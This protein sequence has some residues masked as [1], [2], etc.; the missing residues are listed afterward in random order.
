[1][2]AAT[3]ALLVASATLGPAQASTPHVVAVG[4]SYISGVGA[5]GVDTADPCLRSAR[6][7]AAEAARR[8][9]SGFTD[10]SCAGSRIGDVL[11][12]AAF[13]P[14][15]ATAV[16]VQVGGHDAG[17]ASI[18]LACLLPSDNSC[19]DAIRQSESALPSI[20]SG[21][22]DISAAIRRQAPEAT[23]VLIGY[24]LLVSTPKACAASQMAG[25]I[26]AKETNA[27]KALQ[28]KLDA[29]IAAAAR[30][31]GARF[32]DWPRSVD[33]HS[34]CSPDSWIWGPGSGATPSDLLHPTAK[35]HAA[36]GRSLAETLRR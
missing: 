2:L 19:L 10:R 18:A 28:G 3:G 5:G 35:A 12:Q 4:D 31:S 20:T 26:N 17:Y 16:L 6:S 24:P 21:L 27:L 25:L 15:D 23:V 8:T 13:I 7:F 11:Q 30:T 29:A 9:G 14:A 36:L 34:L 1:M 32:V 22:I 33:R